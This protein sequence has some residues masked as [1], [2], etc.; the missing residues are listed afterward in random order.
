MKKLTILFSLMLMGLASVG[1]SQVKVSDED[2][3]KKIDKSDKDIQNVKKNTKA[4]VWV[5]RGEL[6]LSLDEAPTKGL[7]QGM[8][9]TSLNVMYGGNAPLTEVT[10]GE[11]TMQKK[12]TRT[13]EGYIQ[14]NRLV[15]WVS[16]WAMSKGAL[17]ESLK[18]FQK[19]YELDKSASKDISEGLNK[20]A[21]A[22]RQYAANYF[23]VQE[24]AKAAASFAKA[25]EVSLIE[26][27]NAM[28]TASI[29]NAGY[30]ATV[31]EDFA[32][33]AKYLESA[34]TNSYYSDGDVYYLL[35][36]CY[37]GNKENDKAK[38]TLLKGLTTFPKNNKII[39]GLMA[40]YTENG[41]DSN[42]IIPL[43]ENAIAADPTNAELY[44]GLGRIYDKMGESDKSIEAFVKVAELSPDDYRS[45]FNLGL[46][47]IKKADAM[48]EEMRNT[49][50]TS[51]SVYDAAVAE[52]NKVYIRAIAPLE[53]AYELNPSISVSVELLKN[54]CFRLRDE[55][56]MMD[57][58]NKY[59]ELFKSLPQE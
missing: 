33:G 22:Y 29:F 23:A 2:W 58:Y 13:F 42:E 40:F 27:L 48:N 49:N 25:Y 39:E 46:L 12:K 20:I 50:Y 4:D 32:N 14:D 45:N 6:Y 37:V 16:T 18:S 5:D 56:G 7:Y 19:A 57:K 1:M 38:E 59:N 15:G 17:D 21:N 11:E 34:L 28:D 53:R 52:V 36:H 3:Q 41:G 51:Q 24:T 54:V 9:L 10:L 30:L 55:D 26:P 47:L 31:A 35:Y 44:D 8:D 43:V